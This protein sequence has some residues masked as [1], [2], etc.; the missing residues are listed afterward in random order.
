ML[1]LNLNTLWFS[2]EHFT[3][4]FYN[5][6][7]QILYLLL[8]CRALFIITSDFDMEATQFDYS[9]KN[10]P[11]PSEKDYSK[12]LIE[13]TEELCRRMRWKAHFY[14]NPRNEHKNK[15]TYGFNSKA[16][17]SQNPLN[18]TTN[19][20]T[21][22][23]KRKIIWYNP[24]YSKNVSNNVGQSFLKIIDEEFP[25]DHPLHKIF[26]CNTVKISY[27]CMPNIKQT[28]DGHNKSTL[29]TISGTNQ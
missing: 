1:Y 9:T 28:I 20:K 4:S 15:E 21:R 26:N 25:A 5:R 6:R 8:F 23:R 19:K 12:K 2:I 14:L 27:S 29:S 13:K 17:P 7:T 11:V 3:K 22:S 24:P 10:I 16:T 18:L